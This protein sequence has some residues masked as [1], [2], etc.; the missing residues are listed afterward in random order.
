[1]ICL[2]FV[3]AAGC[4]PGVS[5]QE[6]TSSSRWTWKEQ[7]SMGFLFRARGQNGAPIHN[8]N[9]IIKEVHVHFLLAVRTSFFSKNTLM[10]WTGEFQVLQVPQVLLAKILRLTGAKRR[11][12]SG[13]IPVITSNVII[14]ATPSNP[15][16]NPTFSNPPVPI[17]RFVT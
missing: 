14:P 15:S 7:S 3:A 1:M 11:E 4:L 5:L 10:F 13:M 17:S 2:G 9:N 16:S 8:I 12:F 6:T